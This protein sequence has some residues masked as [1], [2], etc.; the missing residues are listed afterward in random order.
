MLRVCSQE[1]IQTKMEV[2]I[3]FRVP[4]S[5]LELVQNSDLELVQNMKNYSPLVLA[6]WLGTVSTEI[7]LLEKNY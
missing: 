1:I 5:D 7:K 3:R 2:G 6:G 4:K